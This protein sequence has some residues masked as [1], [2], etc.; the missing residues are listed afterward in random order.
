MMLSDKGDLEAKAQ[1]YSAGEDYFTWLKWAAGTPLHRAVS[2]RNLAAARYLLEQGADPL[3]VDGSAEENAATPLDLA[4]YHHNAPMLKLLLDASQ[5]DIN[6]IGK[7]GTTLFSRAISVVTYPKAIHDTMELLMS[8]GLNLRVVQITSAVGPPKPFTK[9]MLRGRRSDYYKFDGLYLAACA[10]G[11]MGVTA[12]H[13]SI[14]DDRK[15]MFKALLA[16]G[17]NPSIRFE[18]FGENVEAFKNNMTCLHLVA[19]QEDL[20]LFFSKRLLGY[21]L[22]LDAGGLYGTTPRTLAVL[23]GHFYVANELLEAGPDIDKSMGIKTACQDRW[24]TALERVLAQGING[25]QKLQYLLSPERGADDA[26]QD[27][28]KP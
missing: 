4:M 26:A 5:Y 18:A 13:R 6:S 3:A 21:D 22:D 25:L 19:T 24:E 10:N 8:R 7:Y 2:S 16:A 12:L 28:T 20:D 15:S 27:K 9:N 23:E 11:F 17:A 1:L 14:K